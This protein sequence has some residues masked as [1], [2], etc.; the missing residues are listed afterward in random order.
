M[1]SSAIAT[2]LGVGNRNFPDY[3]LHALYCNSSTTSHALACVLVA[4]LGVC[5]HTFGGAVA[6]AARECSI[7]SRGD[8]VVFVVLLIVVVCALNIIDLNTSILVLT[9]DCIHIHIHIHIVMFRIRCVVSP[10]G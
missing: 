7:P 9:Y 6:R 1:S 3:T 8:V 4:V 5:V 2:T 10:F